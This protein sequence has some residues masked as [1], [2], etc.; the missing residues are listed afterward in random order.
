MTVPESHPRFL[1]LSTRNKLVEEWEK[2]LVVTQGLIAHGRGEAFDYLL[3]EVT[4]RYAAEA[5]KVAAAV[6][7][8]AERPVISVNG[9][10][11]ALSAKDV[12]S[13]CAE[14]DCPAEVNIFHR[15]EDRVRRLADR[16]RAEGCDRVLG[17]HPDSRIKGLDHSRALCSSEGIFSSDVVLVPLEDGDRCEA[18]KSMNKKVVTV[19]LN[20][21][22]R[23]S[24]TADISIVDNLIRAMPGILS[25]LKEIRSEMRAGITDE[26]DLGE[27]I[28]GFS[29]RDNLE[30]SLD[31]MARRYLKTR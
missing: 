29:N 1:S 30:G 5:E 16:L 28:S 17:E 20:P 4:T 24:R 31:L 11:G 19:D 12:C 10:V 25:N 7:L 21:L 6:L 18:L 14:L 2:G 27:W 23:T 26:E 8:T 13:I 15:S 3:G 9:N 22:S